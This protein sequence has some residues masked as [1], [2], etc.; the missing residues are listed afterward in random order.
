M[1]KILP[2]EFT[3][4]TS[5]SCL[6]TYEKVVKLRKIERLTFFPI[7]IYF[8]LRNLEMKNLKAHQ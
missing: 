8:S 4:N 5:E 6:H 7:E 3:R 1:W 2:K